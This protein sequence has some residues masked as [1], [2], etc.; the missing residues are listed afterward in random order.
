MIRSVELA[1]N[2]NVK[3]AVLSSMV[4]LPGTLV[5]KGDKEMIESIGKGLYGLVAGFIDVTRDVGLD[6]AVPIPVYVGIGGVV[7]MGGCAAI[8]ACP[9]TGQAGG[10]I[11]AGCF[12][13]VVLVQGIDRHAGVIP[14][15]GTAPPDA[16][17]WKEYSST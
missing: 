13:Q 10:A 3:L 16:M 17:T 14:T 6:Y 9:V 8:P 15:P 7:I 1:K 4:D 11:Q 2:Y 5:V 12:I